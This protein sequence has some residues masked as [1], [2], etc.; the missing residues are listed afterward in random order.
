MNS[1]I[2]PRDPLAAAALV[3]LVLEDIDQSDPADRER[4][5][6]DLLRTAW[7]SRRAQDQ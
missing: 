3:A 7:P 6:A 1:E 5:L 2:F 4:L